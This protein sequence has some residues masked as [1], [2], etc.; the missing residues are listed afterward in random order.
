M[1]KALQNLPQYG[2]PGGAYA[3]VYIITLPD[4]KKAVIKHIG[5][6]IEYPNDATVTIGSGLK[7]VNDAIDFIKQ[8]NKLNIEELADLTEISFFLVPAN[9][10]VYDYT[11]AIQIDEHTGYYINAQEYRL[12]IVQPYHGNCLRTR[13]RGYPMLSDEEKSGFVQEIVSSCKKIIGCLKKIPETLSI[14]AKPDNFVVREG[15]VHYIDIMPPK[16]TG[17]YATD[18]NVTKIFPHNINRSAEV[19]S[20]YFTPSGR[21]ERFLYHLERFLTEP[22][23]NIPESVVN[24]ILSQLTTEQ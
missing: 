19:T 18:P 22:R 5:R 4:G 13:I 12:L 6:S 11:E 9:S 8:F 3:L 24:M 23:N 10:S 16:I 7:I 2:I 20:Q 21:L 1:S 17:E 15:K 14:D